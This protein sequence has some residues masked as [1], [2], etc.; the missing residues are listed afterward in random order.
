ME[1]QFPGLPFPFVFLSSH[2]CSAQLFSNNIQL[3]ATEV[4]KGGNKDSIWNP[5]GRLPFRRDILG[6]SLL[7]HSLGFEHLL[8]P[9]PV[10]R[11]SHCKEDLKW[12][13]HVLCGLSSEQSSCVKWS[14][15]LW[16]LW[17]RGKIRLFWAM[18]RSLA[19]YPLIPSTIYIPGAALAGPSWFA[20]AFPAAK[21]HQR[22]GVWSP[23]PGYRLPRHHFEHSSCHGFK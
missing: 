1:N 23:D 7:L 4:T 5:K 9:C 20:G 10:P 11:A 17:D 22:F 19:G 15:F 3:F 21:M 14:G 12:M 8:S 13:S 6:V 18:R 16:I 2:P